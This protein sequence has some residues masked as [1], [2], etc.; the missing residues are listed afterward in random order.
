MKVL[1]S[2]QAVVEFDG[3]YYYNNSVNSTYK[4]YLPLGDEIIV[5]SYLKKVS[6][7]KHDRIDSDAIKFLFIEKENSLKTVISNSKSNK[8]KVKECVDE[9]D[10]CVAH[11]PC[12]HSI[13]VIEYAR[14]VKKP[15]MTVVCG[16]PFDALWNYNWKGKLV[17]PWM[18]L[19]LR[20]AQKNAEYSIYVTK[21]FLEARYPNKGRFIGCSN[22]NISTGI[23]GVLEKRLATIEEIY[24]TNRKLRIGTLGAVDVYYKGQEFIIRAIKKM[25]EKGVDF[26]YLIIGGGDTS[27]LSGVAKDCGVE[28][29][30]QFTGPLPHDKI[31]DTIDRIDIYAQP[32]LTEG[33]PRSV[34]EAMSRGCL[35]IGTKVG[36]IPELVYPEYLF[37]K[38]DVNSIASILEHITTDD[39]KNQ[40]VKNYNAAKDYDVNELNNR[41]HN[42]IMSFKERYTKKIR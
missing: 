22:V 32:S 31:L 39:L 13:Q 26:E 3:K 1:Y 40:A 38:G 15:C 30:V 36:G 16:C 41:R 27:R 35:T 34:I 28:D 2:T 24:R 6:S 42:F 29:L 19:R 33:L 20:K 5:M 8:C 25:R 7:S 10:F 4:R 9:V 18:F 21:S 17:A 12:R 37:K 23:E 11:V 14:K